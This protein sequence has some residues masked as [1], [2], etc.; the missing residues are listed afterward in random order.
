MAAAAAGAVL[1][2][3]LGRGLLTRVREQGVKL[4]AALRSEFGQHLHVGDIRGR[5][6]FRGI[7]FVADRETKAPFDPSRKL[8]AEL[9]K[10]AF[11]A[12]LICYPMGGT[13]DGQ[14]GDHILLAPPFII[15]DGQID[16][17]V[18]KLAVAIRGAL[19][20]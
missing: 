3:I 6:L 5:G 16:E 8:H 11:D 20:T 19:G 9:K 18:G 12:G 7:E 14:R 10:R 13:I 15:E 2:A 17:L 1:Q 4:D